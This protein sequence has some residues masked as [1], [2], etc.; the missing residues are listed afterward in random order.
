MYSTKK[1]QQVFDAL[2]R[3]LNA[4]VDEVKSNIQHLFSDVK[5]QVEG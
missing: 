3:D 2:L 1:F 5:V 4:K